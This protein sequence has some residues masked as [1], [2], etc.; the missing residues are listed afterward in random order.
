MIA[1]IVPAHNEEDDLTECLR[2]IDSASRCAGLRGE[3]VH[4][5]VVA[6]ACTDRTVEVARRCG[7]NTLSVDARNVGHARAV[8][9]QEALAAGARWLAFTDADSV[10][11]A[12][13][14]S[15]QLALGSDAVCGTIAVRDWGAYGD[16]VR[17][18]FA[19]TYTDAEGHSHIHGANLGVSAR[20]YRLVGGFAP[21]A[22]SEDVALV[23]S[24]EFHGARIAWSALPRVS[25]SARRAF[26]AP[27]GFGAAL[28]EVERRLSGKGPPATGLEALGEKLLSG[29]DGPWAL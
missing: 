28:Q 2:S 27:G 24:L 7:V 9:A 21:L 15:A 6:D 20:A 26:R 25:T 23:R 5:F 14:L 19:D 18:Q 10:V 12:N 1:V 3:A 8:G 11:A 17:E 29:A 13:W 4:V 22:S 16:A